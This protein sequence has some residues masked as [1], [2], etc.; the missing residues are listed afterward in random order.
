MLH[1]P[2]DFN[3]QDFL[4]LTMKVGDIDQRLAHHIFSMIRQVVTERNLGSRMRIAMKWSPD[5]RGK[6][7]KN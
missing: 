5:S 1:F 3:W 2:K 4:S 7:E 6:S